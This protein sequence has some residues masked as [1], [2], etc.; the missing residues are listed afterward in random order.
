MQ[1]ETSE[2]AKAVPGTERFKKQWVWT[3]KGR[4]NVTLHFA[5]FSGHYRDSEELILVRIFTF[6]GLLL[7]FQRSSLLALVFARVFP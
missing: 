5:I 3:S 4:V 2:K 1:N 7:V 6:G